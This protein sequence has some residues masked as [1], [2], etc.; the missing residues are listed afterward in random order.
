MGLMLDVVVLGLIKG[1]H[2]VVIAQVRLISPNPLGSWL[3]V[4]DRAIQQRFID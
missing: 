4:L 1:S 3:G 2:Y